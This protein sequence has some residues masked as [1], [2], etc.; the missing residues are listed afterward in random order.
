[1]SR[2]K[3]E[4]EKAYLAGQQLS[5]NPYLFPICKKLHAEWKDG[6]IIKQ[7]TKQPMVKIIYHGGNCNDG[8]GS[9]I[10]AAA[11]LY[12]IPVEGKGMVHKEPVPWDWFTPEDAVFILDFS[13]SREDLLKI[14]SMV[15]ELTVLDHH[16]TAQKNLEGL[17]FCKFDMCKSGVGLTWDY[18]HPGEEM[19]FMLRYIQDRDLW[20]Y[21][22]EETKAFNAGIATVTKDLR[23]WTSILQDES[24]VL[25]LI[26]TGHS[27]LVYSEE[28][29]RNIAKNAVYATLANQP[30]VM[31]NSAVLMSELGDYLLHKPENIDKVKF[32]VIWCVRG[33]AIMFSVRSKQGTDNSCAELC[34]KFGGGGHKHAAGFTSMLDDKLDIGKWQFTITK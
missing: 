26:A 12:P 24:R 14:K 27:I 31:V 15:K 23:N 4:G 8:F 33:N 1:V 20:K 16:E 9:Y 3:T 25:D 19:P 11:A 18:F 7:Q 22:Y 30:V 6:F 2:A 10:V 5:D 29:V 32:A 21:E 28:M 13:F 34:Q 17:D